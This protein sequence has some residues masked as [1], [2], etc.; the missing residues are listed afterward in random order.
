MLFFAD[1]CTMTDIYNFLVYQFRYSTL[2]NQTN[3]LKSNEVN[4]KFTSQTQANVLKLPQSPVQI[5]PPNMNIQIY[6]ERNI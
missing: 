3:I 6:H 5:Y 1:F 2:E 4:S